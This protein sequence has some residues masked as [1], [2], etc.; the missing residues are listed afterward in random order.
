MLT[1]WNGRFW[2]IVSLCPRSFPRLNSLPTPRSSYQESQ[3][4]ILIPKSQ[5]SPKTNPK[6]L[7]NPTL[8]FLY[9]LPLRSHPDSMPSTFT[10]KSPRER[11]RETTTPLNNRS[12][13]GRGKSCAHCIFKRRSSRWLESIS[14]REGKRG[15]RLI[16]MDRSWNGSRRD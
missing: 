12:K 5:V 4:P 10:K 13:W 6:D 7:R 9:F 8:I 1:S 15:E 14:V 16:L 3:S 11:H 2:I